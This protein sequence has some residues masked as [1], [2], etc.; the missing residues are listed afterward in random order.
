MRSERPAGRSRHARDLTQH[1]GAA[2][3]CA[4]GPARASGS[5]RL[6]VLETASVG[7]DVDAAVGVGVAGDDADAADA[8]P[9]MGVV[10]DAEPRGAAVGGAEDAGDVLDGTDQV[11]GLV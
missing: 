10:V 1:G 11:Q 5:G 8:A 6:A 2:A 3:L 7:A 9:L 4:C